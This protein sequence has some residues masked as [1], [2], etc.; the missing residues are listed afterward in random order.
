MSLSLLIC[1][2]SSFHEL[3]QATY[4]YVQLVPLEKVIVINRW[5]AV[6]KKF[7]FFFFAKCS[8]SIYKTNLNHHLYIIYTTSQTIYNS[9]ILGFFVF[10]FPL[11][12]EILQWIFVN[13]TPEMSLEI[14]YVLSIPIATASV[15]IPTIFS[16]LLSLLSFQPQL[17]SFSF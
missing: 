15:H 13:S 9:L 7:F 6:D 10:L 17:W 16:W 1:V 2:S 12:Q 11:L 5:Q 14:T 8:F 4:T 3:Y